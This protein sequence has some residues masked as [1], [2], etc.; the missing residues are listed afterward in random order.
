[1]HT[2]LVI[3][4]QFKISCH[5]HQDDCNKLGEFVL[6][7]TPVAAHTSHSQHASK[8]LAKTVLRSS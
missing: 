3:V 8:K 5:A 7:E 2:V 1:M 6:V 4:R